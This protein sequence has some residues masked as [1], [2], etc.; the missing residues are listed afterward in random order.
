M[1]RDPVRRERW[2]LCGAMLLASGCEGG[3]TGPAGPEGPAGPPGPIGL[4]GEPG[5]TGAEG[6]T[7]PKGEDGSPG[8][9]GGQGPAGVTGPPGPPGDNG[10]PGDPGPQGIAGPA[11]P[12]GPPGVTAWENPVVATS[13]AAGYSQTSIYCSA[14]KLPLSWGFESVGFTGAVSPATAF[15]SVNASVVPNLVGWT[16]SFNNSSN[17]TISGTVNAIC[18]NVN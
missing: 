12:Q 10:A 1:T 17:A 16:L 5:E 9:Q 14:G 18:A 15:V 2:L 6:A 4:T 11:G 8:I 3:A 7:G 13:F